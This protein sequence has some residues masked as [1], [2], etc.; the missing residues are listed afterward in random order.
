MV[1]NNTKKTYP[2]DLANFRI[3]PAIKAEVARRLSEEGYTNV[4]IAEI[5]DSTPSCVSQYINKHRGNKYDL[6]EN[7]DEMFSEFI[8][9]LKEDNSDEILFYGITQICN[10]IMRQHYNW[11]KLD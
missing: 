1:I 4:A 9:V 6:P 8:N 7:L 5:L 2:Q 3:L 11:D 10:E